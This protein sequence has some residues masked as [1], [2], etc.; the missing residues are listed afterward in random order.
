MR[1]EV[2]YIEGCP[3]YQATVRRVGAVLSECG[4]ETDIRSIR[5]ENEDHAKVL[6]FLGSPT[7]RIDGVDIEPGARGSLG[8][9]FG[10]RVYATPTGM[11]CIPPAALIRD[12]I[13]R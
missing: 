11:E 10:C 12:A 6:R 7:V 9:G 2:L 4:L 13:S 3:A 8:F 5:I 1:I